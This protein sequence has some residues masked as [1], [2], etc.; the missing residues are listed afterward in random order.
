MQI[1]TRVMGINYPL[2]EESIIVPYDQQAE[3]FWGY[4]KT[5]FLQKQGLPGG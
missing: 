2:R 3:M 5:T 4:I 1:N